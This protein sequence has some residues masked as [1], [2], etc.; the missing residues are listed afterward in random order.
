MLFRSVKIRHTA[1]LYR[2][3]YTSILVS[4]LAIIICD[5]I[6]LALNLP[7]DISLIFYG[8]AALII[9]FFTE[10]YVPQ[11]MRDKILANAVQI[12]EMGVGCFDIS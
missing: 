1:R 11:A 5:A 7:I 4:F 8:A 10:F 3:K 6:G 9:C 2:K 12:A